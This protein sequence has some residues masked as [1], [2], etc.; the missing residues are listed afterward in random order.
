[1]AKPETTQSI[2]VVGGGITGLTAAHQLKK[3][4][5]K[6]VLFEA[7]A[8]L[9]GQ[10]SS[11]LQD[12][13]LLDAGPHTLL[14]RGRLPELIDELGLQKRVQVAN[15]RAK[16][17]FVVRNAK[18]H[19]LPTNLAT[20][21]ATPILSRSAKLRLL[22]EPFIPSHSPGS[23]A[24]NG[25]NDD[26][27]LADFVSRRLGPEVLDYLVDPMVAGTFAGDA[28]QLSLRHAVPKLYQ[29]EQTHGSLLRAGLAKA[30]KRLR[31]I[32]KPSRALDEASPDGPTRLINFDRG[33]Q[34]LVDELAATL[35]DE[36][37]LQ[38]EV[39][40][41]KKKKNGRW[42][43]RFQQKDGQQN[44]KRR[45]KTVDAIY[46]ALP[47]NALADISVQDET[48]FEALRAIPYAPVSVVSLGFRR[49]DVEHPLD[50]FG[51][52]VPRKEHRQIL[53]TLFMSTLFPDRA[54]DGQVLLTSFVGGARNPEYADLSAE[55]L[56]QRVWSDLS[57]LLG[58]R[59][60]PTL[61]AHRYWEAAIPQY[62]VGHDVFDNTV[63]TVEAA[64]GGLFVGG[65]FLGGIAVPDR[66]GAGYD[67]AKRIETYLDA[68]I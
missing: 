43:V 7:A 37:T 20:F 57:D 58:V 5:F 17:R 40:A 56:Y 47:A 19:A 66:V 30:T 10:M 49:A 4:G 52:L 12:G 13:F 31:A 15:P 67:S 6:V 21:L 11:T 36:T 27:S 29:L 64:Y 2:A 14:E 26:E 25:A 23:R 59:G 68:Q 48:P 28:T 16:K 65:N 1:M 55:L 54:P 62:S 51:M 42:L 24:C 9:G 35:R 53:G 38:S 34:V 46:C 3:E 63:D 39:Y 33:T 61:R 22:A 60:E 41:L 32:L 18:P 44:I 50:G 45:Q 8:A